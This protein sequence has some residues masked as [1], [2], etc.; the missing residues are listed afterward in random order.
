MDEFPQGGTIRASCRLNDALN[1]PKALGGECGKEIDPE[2][3]ASSEIRRSW[4]ASGRACRDA[5][6]RARE[7]KRI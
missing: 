3:L 6:K 7:F 2:A 5:R 4:R 1:P